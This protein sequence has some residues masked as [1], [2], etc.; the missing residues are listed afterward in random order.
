MNKIET[1]FKNNCPRKDWIRGCMQRNNLSMKRANII[2]AAQ[3][4]AASNHFLIYDFF[5]IIEKIIKEQ[6]FGPP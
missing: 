3:K 5:D 2:S 6:N 4:S 1:L